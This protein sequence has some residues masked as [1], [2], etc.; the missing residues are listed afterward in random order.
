M[1]ELAV[2]LL[3]GLARTTAI[4][5]VAALAVYGLLRLTRAS[6]PAVHR[7]AWC[8]VLLQ[9]WLWFRLPV[10]IPWYEAVGP[11][12]P[13]ESAGGPPRDPQPGHGVTGLLSAPAES[14]PEANPAGTAGP[15]EADSAIPAHPAGPSEAAQPLWP[16]ILTA[17][18]FAGMGLLVAG[19]LG[20]YLVFLSL[21]PRGQRAGEGWIDQWEEL[22]RSR[23]IRRAIPMRVTVRTGPVL[24][25]LPRGY[26]LLVPA[27]LWERLDPAGRLSILRHELA[28]LERG[29]VWKSLWVRLLALPHWFNPLAWWAVRRFDEAAEWACDQEACGTSPQARPEYAKAL[30][31]LGESAAPVLLRPA[32]RG[33]RLSQRIRRLL[34]S[35]RKEDSLMKKLIVLGAALVLL[36]VCLLRFD[37]VAKEPAAGVGPALPADSAPAATPDAAT[38]AL[39][40]GP[41]DAGTISGRIIDPAGKPASGADVWLVAGTFYGESKLLQKAVA[42]AGGR[43]TFPA[44]KLEFPDASPWLPC[45][46]ARDARGNI[47]GTSPLW[48][49]RGEPPRQDIVVK[50]IEVRNYQGRLADA[51]GRAIARATIR[52]HVLMPGDDRQSRESTIVYLFPELVAG[53]AVQ[54]DAD[55]KFLLR[56][57]PAKGGIESLVTASGFGSPRVYW[58]LSESVTIQLDRPGSIE[59]KVTC[60]GDPKVVGAV[61][62]RLTTQ[63]DRDRP[64]D[65]KFVVSDSGD[66]MTQQDGSFRFQDV[67]P[68]KYSILAQIDHGLP[69][70]VEV[71]NTI[72]VRPGAP[73]TGITIPFERA[74]A[75]RGKVVDKATGAGIKG[76]QVYIGSEAPERRWARPGEPVSDGEGM[77]RAYVR[78]GAIFVITRRIPEGY[79]APRR[80]TRPRQQEARQDI[81]WPTIALERPATLEG[82]VV[83]ESGNPA[84]SAEVHYSGRED[85]RVESVKTGAG[86]K[87]ALTRLSPE[88][89]LLIRARTEKAATAGETVAVPGRADAPVRL[90]ISEKTAFCLRGTIVDDAGVPIKQAPIRL[91][92]Q[93]N[94][95]RGSMRFEIAS[96]KTDNQ[97]RFE[98]G[99]LWPGEKYHLAISPEGYEKRD[100]PELQG[101]SGE[102]RDLAKIVLTGGRA[103]VAGVVVDSAGKPLAGVRVFNSGD[104]PQPLE[105][106]TDVAGRYRLEGFYPGPV[107]VFAEKEGCRFTGVRT[108]AGAGGV[109]LKMLRSDEAL[110]RQPQRLPA[111][112]FAEQ[113]KMARTLLEKLWAAGEHR[114]MGIAIAAMA[115]LDRDL[116]LKWSAELGGTSD[117]MVRI[118]AAVAI[119]DTDPEGALSLLAQAGEAGFFELMR[120][121]E[122]Y[123]SS[124]PAKA[125]RFVAEAALQGRKMNQPMRAACLARA[126]GLAVQLGNRESGRK[127][128]EEAAG[129]IAGIPQ[130][131]ARAIVRGAVVQGMAAYDPDRA[132]RFLETSAGQ[133][134][135]DGARA[136]PEE[137]RA[138]ANIAVAVCL[139]DLK[140]ALAI[141]Q[142]PPRTVYTR[143]IKL[144]I[145]YRLAPSRP[146]DALRVVENIEERESPYGPMKVQAYGWLATAVA[147]RDKALAC[148]L[149]DRGLA[150]SLEKRSGERSLGATD[151][152]A[153]QAA[154]LAVQA[155]QIGYPDMESVT[156]RVLA[157]RPTGRREASAT[158]VLYA[159]AT[160]ASILALADPEAARHILQGIEARG[161]PS[162]FG[163]PRTIKDRWFKAWILADPR[164]AMELADQEIA[165]GKGK[166]S[167]DIARS[168]LPEMADILTIRPPERLKYLIRNIGLWSPGEER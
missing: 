113:Q 135:R 108:M 86:G 61:K 167:G 128:V 148:S 164:H 157:A 139:D 120:L 114:Q 73:A 142:G 47:G 97:G 90:A 81:T 152:N 80:E 95:E 43:F 34:D 136:G 17:V 77:Y 7:A 12:L 118:T 26:Q 154:L 58:V 37:L 129:M 56:G 66:A 60:P 68:G 71:S 130:P 39:T 101:Q 87:F 53:L 103:V 137:D 151:T 2:T 42:D 75:V 41:S 8:L 153:L 168:G 6:S 1:S 36:L 30:V 45:L 33:R 121:A 125:N 158:T 38:P 98:L 161:G 140:T 4:L 13:A 100:L 51:S 31:L 54:S 15:T 70:Y 104:A 18:W 5:A 156:H 67:P 92:V 133:S 20:C 69:Y 79:L 163:D 134:D 127:L 126:G 123:A 10:G 62:V 106:K 102:T 63:P 57:V 94:L 82:V 83:D 122:K 89:R 74:I 145:A 132:L 19:W 105:G 46:V 35:D 99:G 116:A 165:A 93:W 124:D 27:S 78:P 149:I 52:P 3:L 147:P 25:R 84:P 21:L 65:P 119:A 107:Y 91:G 166:P 40:G 49:E 111:P 76:V 112:S 146:A 88:G 160:M 115:R 32:A 28:H 50:L 155:S 138:R 72:D 141:V 55:G 9:G 144:R 143:F 14:K 22:L 24:C 23:R 110:P 16:V 109:T 44:T 150:L 29:D 64:R 11:A 131:N 59:G 96:C 48:R 159:S 85:F 162:A 117:A